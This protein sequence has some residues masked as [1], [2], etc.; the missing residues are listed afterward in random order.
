MKHFFLDT[1]FIIDYFIREDYQGETEK[2]LTI[3]KITRNEKDY[4]FSDIP[5]MSAS[6][7]IM[8]MGAQ[9]DF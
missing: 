3:G 5:V 8:N 9:H 1:N 2:F 7:Y 6:S 4:S